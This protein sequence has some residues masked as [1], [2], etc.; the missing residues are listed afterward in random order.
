MKQVKVRH[1]QTSIR[2]FGRRLAIDKEMGGALIELALTTPLLLLL[3]LGAVEFGLADYVAIEVTNAAR[4]GVQYGTQN[5]TTAADTTGIQR[6]STNEASNITLGATTVVPSYV[7]SDQSTP[8]GT[9]P[10]CSSSTA[11]LETII[12]VK[13]QATFTP[14]IHI[15]GISP[16]FTLHGQAT[17]KVSQ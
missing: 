8:T 13:T 14:T 15:P 6:A 2:R 9:P 1:S 17:Q 5:A 12:T 16:T 11:A 7:C 3:L 10:T 4:A